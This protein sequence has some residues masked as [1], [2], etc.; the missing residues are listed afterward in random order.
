MD[1]DDI[2]FEWRCVTFVDLSNG[3]SIGYTVSYLDFII[4][5]YYVIKRKV[6][7]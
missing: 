6:C 1:W 2:I 5:L 4:E 3:Y 7:K